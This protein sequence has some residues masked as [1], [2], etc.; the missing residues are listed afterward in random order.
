M[1]HKFYFL[2]AVISSCILALACNQSTADERY[3]YGN[4]YEENGDDGYYYGNSNDSYNYGRG[5]GYSSGNPAN[6]MS[7]RR[8][9]S[10]GYNS[11]GQNVQMPVRAQD[12][13]FQNQVQNTP[14]A[15][16]LRD[17]SSEKFEGTIQSL[18]KVRY[19]NGTQIEMILNT[20]EGIKKVTLGPS[21]YIE[22]SKVKLQ[23]GDKVEVKGFRVG[24]NGDEVIVAKEV[25]KNGNVLQ[26]RND[27][28]QPLWSSSNYSNGN[29]SNGY[30]NG[31]H[32]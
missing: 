1:K 30:S 20:N 15:R 19:P 28:R 23:S 17:E 16:V 13:T 25:K 12:Q 8:G 18:N 32:H 3:G 5:N 31:S 21:S 7:G 29:Y 10:S 4:S 22:M 6:R 14:P 2:S 24:A 26:L 11:D 9:C 27:Q